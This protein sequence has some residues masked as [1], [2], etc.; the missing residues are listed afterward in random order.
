ML[1]IKRARNVGMAIGAVGLIVWIVALEGILRTMDD[2]NGANI[3]AGFL[4]LA[5]RGLVV[6]GVVVAVVFAVV[7]AVRK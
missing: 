1:M 6:I 2:G 7:G 5:G 3:G 4:L